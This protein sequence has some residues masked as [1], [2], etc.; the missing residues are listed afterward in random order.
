MSRGRTLCTTCHERALHRVERSPVGLASLLIGAAQLTAETW[1]LTVPLALALHVPYAITVLVVGENR[2]LN[3]AFSSTL[4]LLSQLLALALF[5]GQVD[6]GRT[7]WAEAAKLVM[8][9]SFHAG[10][11][12][13]LVGAAILVTLPL[14]GLGIYLAVAMQQAVPIAL[15]EGSGPLESLKRSNERSEGLGFPV[16]RAMLLL[17]LPTILATIGVAAVTDT[18][19]RS[20]DL[21]QASARGVQAV[22]VVVAAISLVPLQALQVVTW[23]KQRPIRS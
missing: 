13:L 16:L 2:G 18:L 8:A 10:A 23:A 15:A 11:T 21:D 5:I 14:C 6:R 3:L 20:G 17:A 19:I 22:A 9:R 1:R 7:S 4:G 12:G